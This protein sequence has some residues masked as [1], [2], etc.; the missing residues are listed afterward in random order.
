MKSEICDIEK[1]SVNIAFLAHRSRALCM[2][3]V[4]IVRVQSQQ[5]LSLTASV[6][7]MI[8]LLKIFFTGAHLDARPTP[9]SIKN[10]RIS[11]R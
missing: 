6:A 9:E 5:N 2:H 11:R 7:N 8:A 3:D 1:I 4:D 10:E